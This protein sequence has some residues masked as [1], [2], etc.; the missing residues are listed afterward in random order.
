[1]PV[2]S[3]DISEAVHAA[4]KAGAQETAEAL[5]RALDCPMTVQVES[6]DRVALDH[7]PGEF[8]DAGLVILLHVETQAALVFLPEASGIV[9]PWS[10]APDATGQSKLSTL[11]QELGMLVLPDDCPADRFE[12]FRV[13]NLGDALRAAGVAEDAAMIPMPVTT[14]DGRR[15]AVRLIWPA[16]KPEA[17]ARAAATAAGAAKAAATKPDSSPSV[18]QVG[19][20]ELPVYSRSLLRV[21][22]PVVVTLAQKRQ[23]VSRIVELGPGC[24]IQ[25]DKSCEEMLDLSL[26]GRMIANGEAVKVGDKFGL[27]ITSIVLPEERFHPLKKA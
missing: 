7:L 21:K 17:V 26:G 10:A 15:A 13:P 18:R 19:L 1:M 8:S 23:P 14:T 16:S 25:F 24:I 6:P 11:A 27:R 5:S 20:Q 12:W 22:V 2:L 3:P 4:C 9:P